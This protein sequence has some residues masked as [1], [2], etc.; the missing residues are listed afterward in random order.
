VSCEYTLILAFSQ[1]EKELSLV[2]RNGREAPVR[3]QR[4]FVIISIWQPKAILLFGHFPGLS[5]V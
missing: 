2:G 4:A 5:D 3:A 1:R